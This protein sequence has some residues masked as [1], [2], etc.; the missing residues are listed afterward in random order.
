[1][2]ID[3]IDYRESHQFHTVNTFSH[4][5][6][7][8]IESL[9]EVLLCWDRLCRAEPAFRFLCTL[10]DVDQCC[11]TSMHASEDERIHLDWPN[12]PDFDDPEFMHAWEG[13]T[14]AHVAAQLSD[15]ERQLSW[16]DVCGTLLTADTDI[17]ALVAI[18]ATRP[19]YW[20]RW[21]TCRDCR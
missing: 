20:T 18:T 9:Q 2:R 16:K 19:P 11:Y 12:D 15:P 4:L 17:D 13:R 5:R 7:S 10:D 14:L 21:C 3:R 6:L 8:A 1:M